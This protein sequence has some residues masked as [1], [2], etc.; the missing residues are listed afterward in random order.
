MGKLV[1]RDRIVWSLTGVLKRCREECSAVDVPVTCRHQFPPAALPGGALN[2]WRNSRSS[3]TPSANAVA[4]PYPRR[5]AVASDDVLVV[6]VERTVTYLPM[7]RRDK[8]R[9]ADR[10]S[11]REIHQCLVDADCRAWPCLE[12]GK[13][14]PTAPSAFHECGRWRASLVGGGRLCLKP[15]TAASGGRERRARCVR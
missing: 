3:I 11:E 4:G 12:R 10:E 7:Y 14:E 6:S 1:F 9:T 13:C 15:R 5:W 8:T 2:I